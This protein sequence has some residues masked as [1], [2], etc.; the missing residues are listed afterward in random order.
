MKQVEDE[1][2]EAA[3]AANIK[4]FACLL[5]LSLARALSCVRV[6]VLLGNLS[7]VVVVACTH[8]YNNNNYNSADF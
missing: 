4:R 6:C 5:A 3:R 2:A 1:E 8:G 7:S